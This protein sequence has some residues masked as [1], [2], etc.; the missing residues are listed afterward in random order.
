MSGQACRAG[1]PVATPGHPVMG[2]RTVLVVEDSAAQR[3]HAA[4]L[5][6]STKSPTGSMRSR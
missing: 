6:R 5:A 1:S 3:R 2:G 4:A